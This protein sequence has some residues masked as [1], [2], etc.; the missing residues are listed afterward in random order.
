MDASANFHGVKVDAG[1]EV[2]VR[3]EFDDDVYE[4]IHLSQV[5]AK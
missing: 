4:T 5:H 3:A 2:E 1:K